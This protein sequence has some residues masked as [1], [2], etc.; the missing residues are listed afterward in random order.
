MN[1]QTKIELISTTMGVGALVGFSLMQAPLVVSGLAGVGIYLGVK[2]LNSNGQ[3]KLELSLDSLTPDV[4]LMITETTEIIKTIENKAKKINDAKIS[5]ELN[6]IVSI[7]YKLMQVLSD[8]VNA[9]TLLKEVRK[10]YQNLDQL[11]SKYIDLK[12]HDKLAQSR[13][14]QL[15]D[16]FEKVLA[17]IYDS[18][19]GY[20][21]K[22]L[23]SDLQDFEVDLKVIESKIDRFR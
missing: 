7:G 21:N 10:M 18:L 16:D 1:N 20:Y 13:Q 14:E 3:A 4:V 5:D 12:T 11:L 2:L 6:K 17:K 9:A 23:K 15:F 19:V 22:G 8:E